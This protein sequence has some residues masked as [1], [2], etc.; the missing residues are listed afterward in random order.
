MIETQGFGWDL[1]RKQISPLFDMDL[2]V[3]SCRN[4]GIAFATVEAK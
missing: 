4:A 1:A 3:E 2:V